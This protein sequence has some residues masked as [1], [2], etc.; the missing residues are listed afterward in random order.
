MTLKQS[1]ADL[2]LK[3]LSRVHRTILRLSGGRVGRSAFGMPTV[4]L[5]TVGRK[6]G[7][8]RSTMLTVPVVEGERLVLVASKG[9][10]DRDPDWYQN[11]VVHPD[12]ETTMAGQ[13]RLM[14]ARPATPEE[15]IELW[16]RVERSYKGYAHY[17]R[18]TK[19]DIPLVIC[20]PR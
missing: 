11:L 7:R 14:R 8:A 19:R 17:R 18:R 1:Y 6:S 3:T 13:R 9:G 20:E 15:K 5:V 4:E 12:V 16:P 2:G 10:D